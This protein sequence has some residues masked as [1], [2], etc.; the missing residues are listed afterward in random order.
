MQREFFPLTLSVVFIKDQCATWVAQCLEFDIAAQGKTI[1]DAQRAFERT[2][3]GQ[4]MLD[5]H[6]KRQPLEGIG[7]MA[8]G[9]CGT[10]RLADLGRGPGRMTRAL[11]VNLSQDGSDMCAAGSLWLA[12][13]ARRICGIGTSVRVGIT[14]DADRLLRFYETGN[15][16]VSGVKKRQ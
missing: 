10:T 13:T 12:A 1:K 3:L 11:R 8:A 5:L 7:E 4:V 14:R 9:P 6:H 2:F 15:A 16:H